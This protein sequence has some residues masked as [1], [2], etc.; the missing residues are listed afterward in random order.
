MATTKT[1]HAGHFAIVRIHLHIAGACLPIAQLGPDFLV[2][3]NPVPHPPADAEISMSI[4]GAEE[5]WTVRLK[6]G[7]S[8]ERKVRIVPVDLEEH[9]AT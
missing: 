1:A 5:R 9:S 2:F 7:I 3:R 8:G 6:D 4:D